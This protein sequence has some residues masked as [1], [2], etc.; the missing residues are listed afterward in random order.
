MTDSLTLHVPESEDI[1]H[2]DGG[3]YL[4]VPTPVGRPALYLLPPAPREFDR[5]D[6]I[7]MDMDGSSTDTEKLVLRAM[8][9]MMREI[10]LEKLAQGGKLAKDLNKK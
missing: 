2:Y 4:R 8:C 6:S 1:V 3:V 7:V 9:D 10:V 5:V